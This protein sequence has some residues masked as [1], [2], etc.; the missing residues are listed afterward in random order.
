MNGPDHDIHPALASARLCH[1]IATIPR[2]RREREYVKIA[3]ELWLASSAVRD[4][5]TLSVAY[6]RLY[7]RAVLTGWSAAVLHGIEPPDDAVPELCVGPHGRARRGLRMRRY[8]V[9][10]RA[11]T[12]IRGVPVTA[13]RWTAFDIARFSPHVDGVLAMEKFYQRGVSRA[14]MQETVAY[15]AGTW[16]VSRVRRVIDDADPRSESPRETETRLFLKAAGFT[17]F[18]PQVDVPELGYRLDLADPVHK[19]AVEYDGPHHDDPVQQSK[20][21]QRRNRLQAAG[22]I[23][24]VVDRR[25][26]RHQQDEILGQV[27]AAYRVRRFA[28]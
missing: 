18:V 17:D 10:E 12:T 24:I 23:I 28:A 19:I 5:E 15:M 14:A 25:L 16:G 27:E 3:D 7:P 2:R 21:R 20:D 4:F 1:E 8:V 13:L 11:I 6:T 9:P 22:W 26:F